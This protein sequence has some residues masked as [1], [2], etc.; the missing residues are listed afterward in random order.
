MDI[1]TKTSSYKNLQP[2][3]QKGRYEIKRVQQG[4]Y[5][6]VV[7]YIKICDNDSPDCV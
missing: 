2:R 1:P 6:N 4:L 3:L 7:D 5:R